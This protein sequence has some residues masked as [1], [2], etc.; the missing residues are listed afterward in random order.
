MGIEEETIP[1]GKENLSPLFPQ[2]A[3]LTGKVTPM[4][5]HIRELIWVEGTQRMPENIIVVDGLPYHHDQVYI[6]D[7]PVIKLH[8]LYLYHDSL[9]AGHLG[10]TR[11][12]ELVRRSYWWENMVEYIR[13]YVKGCFTCAQNKH[14]NRKPAS[15]MQPLPAPLGPW[16]WTQSDHITGLP[17]SQGHD[18]IYV[19]M[20][21]LTKMTHF[22]PTNTQATAED[23]V[24]LHLKHVWKHHGIPKVHNTDRGSTFTAD[25]TRCFFK[26]LNI[27][28][29]FSTAYH[30][31][32]QGQVEN[33]NKWVETYIQ[34]FCN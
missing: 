20:D 4:D 11:T 14:K 17:R 32:T 7:V 1:E 15:M 18:A 19:V 31:Q 16:E 3:A 34:M 30:P 29:Q 22:I 26:A 5:E 12:Y 2:I 24:Q 25:Y 23:L 9:I 28:Q 27:D 8:I 21:C 13:N 10:Q 6:P 33:N